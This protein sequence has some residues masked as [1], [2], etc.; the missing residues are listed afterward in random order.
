LLEEQFAHI[1]S[2]LRTIRE[3]DKAAGKPLFPEKTQS[4]DAQ[5]IAL[6]EAASPSK[7]QTILTPRNEHPI[8]LKSEFIRGNSPLSKYGARANSVRHQTAP[9]MSKRICST[10]HRPKPQTQGG[11]RNQFAASY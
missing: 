5:L 3:D 8:K 7:T 2:M 6:K 9:Y 1:K 10:E 4:R 11:G